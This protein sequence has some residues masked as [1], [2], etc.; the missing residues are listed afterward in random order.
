MVWVEIMCFP[1]AGVSH[2]ECPSQQ[3]KHLQKHQVT[4]SYSYTLCVHSLLTIITKSTIINIWK[5][6]ML[7]TLYSLYLESMH[8]FYVSNHAVPFLKQVYPVHLT[9]VL[10]F[11]LKTSQPISVHNLTLFLNPSQKCSIQTYSN[12]YGTKFYKKKSIMSETPNNNQNFAHNQNKLH[13]CTK[14]LLLIT[15]FSIHTDTVDVLQ[16]DWHILLSIFNAKMKH[17]NSWWT[18]RLKTI[19][20]KCAGIIY[21]RLHCN[22]WFTHMKLVT[23]IR[24]WH[25]I[26]CSHT[27]IIMQLFLRLCNI[28]HAKGMLNRLLTTIKSI[29]S[30]R[31][32]CKL[33]EQKLKHNTKCKFFF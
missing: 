6:L 29:Y 8:H 2:A 24:I 9:E 7:Y 28:H 12:N 26:S 13:S 10:W 23:D 27:C 4:S 30:L 11:C 5:I 22:G 17:P 25:D 33:C 32:H 15:N 1:L 18:V 16:D 19:T 21:Q 3:P 14:I 31:R 20:T